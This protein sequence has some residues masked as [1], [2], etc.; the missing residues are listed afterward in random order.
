MCNKNEKKYNFIKYDISKHT[1]IKIN[2]SMAMEKILI[3]QCNKKMAKV[4]KHNS[5]S[6]INAAIN[7]SS[8][9]AFTCGALFHF[10]NRTPL[11]EQYHLVLC[12]RLEIQNLYVDKLFHTR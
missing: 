2:I 3:K 9:I 6:I 1:H 5:S 11:N 8:I 4:L 12:N 10:A 7:A